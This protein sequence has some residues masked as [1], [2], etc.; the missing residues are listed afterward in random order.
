MELSIVVVILSIISML[1][2]E[3]A[4]SFLNRSAY[5]ATQAQLRQ[6]DQ[7]VA[8][9]YTN[10]GYIPCPADVTLAPTNTAYG[11]AQDCASLVP[12][13]GTSVVAGMVPFRVL[14]LPPSMA[15]DAFGNKIYYFASTGLIAASSF[16]VRIA[17]IE[18]R[19]GKLAQPCDTASDCSI[20]ALPNMGDTTNSN[21]AAY[22]L[23]SP[24]G[25]QRGAYSKQGIP[26]HDCAKAS[27]TRIDAQNCYGVAPSGSISPPGIALNVLYDSRYNAGSQD[28]NYFD[29]VV[30]WRP[31]DKL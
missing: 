10:Y 3:A 29:D 18:I 17:T 2:L 9:F 19:S 23:V 16:P 31:K 26:I 30:V 12:L 22:A 15:I 13:A 11:V 28:E 5:Q 7:A 24:G 6:I 25:D 8:N 4:T 21:G 14:N 1:G 27:D 20:L